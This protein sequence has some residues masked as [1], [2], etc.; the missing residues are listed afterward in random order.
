VY[1]PLDGQM[2]VSFRPRTPRAGRRAVLLAHADDAASET[3]GGCLQWNDP[4]NYP[5]SSALAAQLAGSGLT[6]VGGD[7]GGTET[8]GASPAAADSYASWQSMVSDEGA[9]SD[10]VV[11]VATSMGF[12]T[13][14]Q[15]AR[16]YPGKVAAIAGIVPAV[17]LTDIY[18][19]NRAGVGRSIR[20]AW[21]VSVGK[22]L[23]TVAD[24][25]LNPLVFA[26]V[27]VR[28]YYSTA[29]KVIMPAMVTAFATL[30]GAT[31]QV[32][33]TTLGHGDA[34]IGATPIPDLAQFLVANGA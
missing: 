22:P 21:G 6:C 32:I 27:A 1:A 13:A 10:K 5:G 7:C 15:V 25:S 4:V 34:A 33:S 17:N 2:Q 16:A 30:V 8:F 11:I 14:Y 24:P 31:T 3:T 20:D 26:G 23:P 19:N 28:L 9:A 12:C 18:R 29:D